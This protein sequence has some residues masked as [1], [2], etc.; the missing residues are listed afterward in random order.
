[1]LSN[2]IPDRLFFKIGDVSELVGV[3]PYV[4]RYWESEF[5]AISPEKSKTGQRVYKKSDVEMLFLIKKLL[6]KERY[7]IEGAKKQ[8]IELRRSGELK[9]VRSQV[10][11]EALKTENVLF[12]SLVDSKIENFIDKSADSAGNSAIESVVVN[13]IENTRTQE[14]TL[15]KMKRLGDLTQDLRA[16]VNR[17]IQQLFG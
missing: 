15:Y 17:P 4:L 8:I 2:V 12:C 13:E 7:S 9:T 3:K 5:T 10:S 11:S 14:F 16:I 1:M 6:Y